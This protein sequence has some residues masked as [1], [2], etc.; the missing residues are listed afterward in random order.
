MKKWKK[1]S[2]FFF[3]IAILCITIIFSLNASNPLPKFQSGDIIFHTSTSN[4]S[5]AILWATKSLYSHMGI[6]ENSN[7][8]LNVI[9]AIG[10]VSRTPLEKWINRGKFKR[11]AVYRFRGLTPKQRNQI[12]HEAQNMLKLPYDKH[13]T[14]ANMEKKAYCSGLVYLA[15]KRSGL[16]L[17]ALQKI[18]TLDVDNFVVRS[19]FEKRYK[20]H[21][22]CQG[23]SVSFEQCW[24][25]VMEDN[26]ITPESII[27]DKSLELIYSNYP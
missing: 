20:S 25:R 19:L 24:N 23:K 13:F 14:T 2:A 3:S 11:Y 1:L 6:I 22:L 12:V 10:V 27:N 9:E 5:F 7:I 15:Y 26:I 4:Q 16:P 18:K 17:G 8:K 21:P